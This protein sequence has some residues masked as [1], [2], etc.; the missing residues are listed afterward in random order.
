MY[1]VRRKLAAEIVKIGGREERRN[2]RE[3]RRAEAVKRKRHTVWY[4][5][6]RERQAS[7]RSRGVFSCPVLRARLLRW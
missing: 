6:A 2:N 5:L 4:R 1:K 7:G 3:K